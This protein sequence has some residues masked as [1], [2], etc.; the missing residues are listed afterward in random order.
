MDINKVV[1]F[2]EK[3]FMWIIVVILL[4]SV[5]SPVIGCWLGGETLSTDGILSY[6][7]SIITGIITLFVAGIALY[8]GKRAEMADKEKRKIEIRPNLQI[9]IKEKENEIFEITI[10]NYGKHPATGIWLYEYPLLSV[11]KSND[12]ATR[13]ISFTKDSKAN[14]N[15]D[16]S[17][18]E[19]GKDSLPAEVYLT[20]GDIDNNLISQNF[21]L[22]SDGYEAMELEYV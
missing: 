14:I 10:E 5:L 2:I 8:Q 7:G 3:K 22:R 1:Q 11:I 15:I 17:F 16:E 6:V 21:K 9:D 4:I 20:Y 18:Y 19:E 12:K 13:I